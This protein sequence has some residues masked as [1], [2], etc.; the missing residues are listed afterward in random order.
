MALDYA[1]NY[2]KCINV[3]FKRIIR[4]LKRMN[5]KIIYEKSRIKPVKKVK[6]ILIL[7]ISSLATKL[8]IK[9]YSY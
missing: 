2:F 7:I 9:K 4:T 5:Y 8:I 1:Q 3:R 6:S